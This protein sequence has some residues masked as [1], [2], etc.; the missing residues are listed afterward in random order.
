MFTN[1]LNRFYF[2]LIF[3]IL[4][5]CNSDTDYPIEPEITF[6][7]FNK[8]SMTQDFLNTD[9]IFV[10]I[11]FT[12]GDG[13]IGAEANDSVSNIFVIDNRSGFTYG[14]YKMPAIPKEG[15]NKGVSGTI[16]FKLY[17]TCCIFP[18]LIPPCTSPEDY[19]TNDLSFDIYI[20]DRKGHK[21]NVVTTDN[22]VLQCK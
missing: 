11:D 22:I 2:L 17:T 13:D 6:V 8:S 19:P 12:D 5:S 4:L 10:S 14:Q 15:A 7:S 16:Q 9:S 21:S 18:D 1:K 3:G 20:V